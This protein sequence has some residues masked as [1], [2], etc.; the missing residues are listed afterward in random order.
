[1]PIKINQSNKYTVLHYI[2][3]LK[4]YKTGVSLKLSTPACT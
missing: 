2:S 1:M 4:R 3:L